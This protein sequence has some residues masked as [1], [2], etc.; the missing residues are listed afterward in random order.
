MRFAYQ[1]LLEG[2]EESEVL[3]ELSS[4]FSLNSRYAYRRIGGRLR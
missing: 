3:K 4:L 1:R 2:K